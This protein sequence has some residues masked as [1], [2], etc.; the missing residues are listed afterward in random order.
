MSNRRLVLSAFSEVC[1]FVVFLS[2]LLSWARALLYPGVSTPPGC[3]DVIGLGLGRES[4]IGCFVRVGSL[5]RRSQALVCTHRV[6]SQFLLCWQTCGDR[7]VLK[8]DPSSYLFLGS[9][10]PYP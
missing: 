5:S 6:E 8:F 9:V 10:P 2:P 3:D 7:P 1:V 4:V